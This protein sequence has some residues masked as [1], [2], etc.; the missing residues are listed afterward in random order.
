MSKTRHRHP[1]GSQQLDRSKPNPRFGGGLRAAG[2]SYA[3]ASVPSEMIGLVAA[4]W[5]ALTVMI[6]PTLMWFMA[7]WSQNNDWSYGQYDK[8]PV[9]LVEKIILNVTLFPIILL[10]FSGFYFIFFGPVMAAITWAIKLMKVRR[11][12][13]DVLGWAL[14]SIVEIPLIPEFFYWEIE[15]LLK[16]GG[17]MMGFLL[18]LGWIAGN[19]LG[20][21]VY[22]LRQRQL[23]R[24]NGEP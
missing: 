6:F 21:L 24:Q 2:E 3:S 16:A 9:G 8:V 22:F 20:G 15:T 11:G 1:A 12:L 17:M 23:H 14:V 7:N 19:G 10:L 4:L 18:I 13:S 5:A